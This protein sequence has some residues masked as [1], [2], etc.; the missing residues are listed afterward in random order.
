MR[1]APVADPFD[2]AWLK[3]AW[4]VVNAQTLQDNIRTLALQ[5]NRQVYIPR[6]QH[7][8]PKRHC[9]VVVADDV[10]DPF[11]E[12]WGL[13]LGDAVHDFRSCLDHIAWALVCGGKTPPDTLKPGHRK[14]IYFPIYDERT[15]FNDALDRELPGVKLRERAIVRAYQPYVSGK[16]NRHGQVLFVLNELSK[17]DKHRS[18]QPVVAFPKHVNWNFSGEPRDCIFRDLAPKTYKGRTRLEPGAELVRFY[19]KKTGPAPY[20]EVEPHFTFQP[21]VLDGLSLDKWLAGTARTVAELLR[22]FAPA[23]ASAKRIVGTALQPPP[24]DWPPLAD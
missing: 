18:I 3:W 7:Y 5:P 17:A 12:H 22:E 8:D 9:I 16:R 6:S 21:S 19:V 15:D 4:G 20:I 11:P 10:R 1:L 23:P 14:K 24:H 2:S 13:L